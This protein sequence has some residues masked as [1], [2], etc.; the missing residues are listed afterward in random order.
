MFLLTL[1]LCYI[2]FISSVLAQYSGPGSF[3]KIKM[4]NHSAS[5]QGYKAQFIH[6]AS[7]WIEASDTSEIMGKIIYFLTMFS[8]IQ[9]T[10]FLSKPRF[11]IALQCINPKTK[12]IQHPKDTFSIWKLEYNLK[13][14]ICFPAMMVP[15]L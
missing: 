6:S 12:W 5:V 7:W 2:A 4:T 9:A 13:V 15:F 14:L 8:D 1:T 10:N 3:F 11:S